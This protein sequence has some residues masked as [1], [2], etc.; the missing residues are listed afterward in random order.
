MQLS[1]YAEFANS[2]QFVKRYSSA[3]WSARRTHLNIV[4]DFF[5]DPPAIGHITGP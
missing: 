2:E 3:L 4:I 5:D 1:S